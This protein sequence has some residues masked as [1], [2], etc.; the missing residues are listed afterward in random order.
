MNEPGAV[1]ETNGPPF[2]TPY[3]PMTGRLNPSF[4]ATS[5][6]ADSA[7][8]PEPSRS[9]DSE[10]ADGDPGE[11][12]SDAKVSRRRNLLIGVTALAVIAAV[13]AFLALRPAAIAPSA[14]RGDNVVC[15]MA[16]KIMHPVNNYGGDLRIGDFMPV[17]AQATDGTISKFAADVERQADLKAATPD[18]NSIVDRCQA[19]GY[20]P[21]DPNNNSFW[22]IDYAADVVR[23]ST[24]EVLQA[25]RSGDLRNTWVDYKKGVFICGVNVSEADSGDVIVSSVSGT[26]NLDRLPTYEEMSAAKLTYNKSKSHVGDWTYD[27]TISTSSGN[28]VH[29]LFA[30]SNASSSRTTHASVII[31]YIEIYNSSGGDTCS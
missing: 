29:G 22:A 21:A 28:V 14:S 8:V 10:S 30:A 7:Q 4:V 11:R 6:T 24:A 15:N 5:S 19:L 18:L 1:D 16:S 26:I 3:D 20:P 13:T 2:E 25:A 27:V 23:K 17:A 31:T 12:A 9:D